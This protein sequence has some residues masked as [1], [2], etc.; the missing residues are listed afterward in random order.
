MKNP[1][2]LLLYLIPTIVVIWTTIQFTDKEVE[3]K[4]TSISMVGDTDKLFKLSNSVR[5][6]YLKWDDCLYTIA[7]EKSIDMVEKD[8]FSHED[9]ET[10]KT[11]TW[12]NIENRCGEYRYAGENLAKGGT[13][14]K[15]FIALMESPK[16]KENIINKNYEYSAVGC[17]KNICTQLF[18][19]Y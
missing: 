15:M 7:V 13:K 18:I 1:K 9:P 17:Y 16:H 6:K 3:L 14:E 12:D 19:K 4:T 10:G 2:I 11:E 8:Y 5:E